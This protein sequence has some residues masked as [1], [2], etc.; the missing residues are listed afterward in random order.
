MAGKKLRNN[1]YTC[2]YVAKNT[3]VNYVFVVSVWITQPQL[4]EMLPITKFNS[5]VLPN[6]GIL[7]F[8][9]L[10]LCD[11]MAF[12]CFVIRFYSDSRHV[13][14]THGAIIVQPQGMMV[15]FPPHRVHCI[16]VKLQN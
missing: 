6:G 5:F 8:N 16:T 1:F 15:D 14:R 10:K 11:S 9:S 4:V 13:R 3:V 2:V 12:E 7:R